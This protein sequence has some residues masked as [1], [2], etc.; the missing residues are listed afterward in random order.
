MLA[1]PPM[2]SHAQM[3]GVAYCPDDSSGQHNATD[4]GL[5][6]ENVTH[7]SVTVT[8]AGVALN[9]V[10][11]A[12]LILRN[13]A[14]DKLATSAQVNVGVIDG[15]DGEFVFVYRF[16]V[17]LG[18]VRADQPVPA[19][20]PT[21]HSLQASTHYKAKIFLTDVKGV[22]AVNEGPSIMRSKFDHATACFKTASAP[23]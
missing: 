11:F 22:G 13:F 8:T 12:N 18:T 17:P 1:A 4:L 20:T 15:E 14:G 23:G 7:D 2:T 9:N 16:Y 5:R 3:V 6:R 19:K 21:F 10:N